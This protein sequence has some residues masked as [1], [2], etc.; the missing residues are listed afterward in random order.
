MRYFTISLLL[1]I[2]T[3]PVR[4]DLMGFSFSGTWA[5]NLGLIHDGDAFSGSLTWDSTSALN[6]CPAD[7]LGRFCR[8]LLSFSFT[9][10]AATGLTVPS[11]P[12]A[13]IPF[14]GALYASAAG[15][16]EGIQ[17]NEKSSVDNQFYIFFGGP[18]RVSESN[19]DF[20]Q[21]IFPRTFTSTPIPEPGSSV[22]T[23]TV[24]GLVGVLA[25][26]RKRLRSV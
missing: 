15:V 6:I 5:G 21:T 17:V 7:P 18:T 12:N 26:R 20:S 11:I 25:W 23:G 8:P 10:P 4:A 9:M 2:G 22:L 14:A 19:V 3:V 24:L 13:Q 1:L 16:F